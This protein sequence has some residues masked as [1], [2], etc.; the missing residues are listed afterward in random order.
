MWNTIK[1]TI[2]IILVAVFFSSPGFIIANDN[3]QML[4]RSGLRYDF[5]G[6]DEYLD[7]TS[8]SAGLITAQGTCNAWVV[9]DTLPSSGTNDFRTIL[10]YGGAA[11]TNSGVLSM[12]I[13]TRI[14]Y[15]GVRLAS[16]TNIEGSPTTNGVYGG[17]SLSVGTL[18]ML[19]MSSSG[20]AWKLYVNGNSETL[21]A[22]SGSNTGDW[23][24][25]ANPSATTHLNIGAT[26]RNGGIVAGSYSD[27]KIDHVSCWDTQL[28]DADVTKLYNSGKPIHP[29]ALGLSS[30]LISFWN[31]GEG[32]NLSVSTSFDAIES[33][34]FTPTNMENADIKT[35]GY[36]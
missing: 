19:T 28:S 20:T 1:K 2:A 7:K 23:F 17:T 33:N 16:R 9:Y 13:R 5:D 4:L 35:V 11:A 26:Y 22:W 12:D 15:S 14:T 21:T 29:S 10:G 6:V 24:S 18:Y 3:H 8:P 32:D 27:G 31:L 34:N 25:D 36:Y 30:G